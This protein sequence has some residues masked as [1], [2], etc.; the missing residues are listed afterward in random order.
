MP[1]FTLDLKLNRIHC[2]GQLHVGPQTTNYTSQPQPQ[3]LL[4]ARRARPRE[5]K[6]PRK[7]KD[8]APM[9]ICVGA[10]VYGSRSSRFFFQRR[11]RALYDYDRLYLPST[12]RV[13]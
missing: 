8:P 13:F 2:H 6:V 10:F 12:S 5:I 7:T 11:Y 3:T 4:I 9:E 1:L